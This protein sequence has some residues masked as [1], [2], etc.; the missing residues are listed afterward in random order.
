MNIEQ[1]AILEEQPNKEA[2][3]AKAIWEEEQRFR[4]G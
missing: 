1:L 4:I 2:P 3:I